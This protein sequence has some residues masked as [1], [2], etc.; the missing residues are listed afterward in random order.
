MAEDVVR[1]ACVHDARA[2]VHDSRPRPITDQAVIQSKAGPRNDQAVLLH[3]KG[4]YE[5]AVQAVKHAVRDSHSTE[6]LYSAHAAT[7]A[8]GA[9]VLLPSRHANRIQTYRMQLGA[10]TV[11]W[12]PGTSFQSA[13]VTTNDI[14]GL[15]NDMH[16]TTIF[17]IIRTCNLG[18]IDGGPEYLKPHEWACQEVLTR[19]AE[20]STITWRTE[21]MRSPAYATEDM[22]DVRQQMPCYIHWCAPKNDTSEE[23]NFSALQRLRVRRRH[24]IKVKDTWQYHT[25]RRQIANGSLRQ[26]LPTTPPIEEGLY[27]ISSRQ[28][29]YNVKQWCRSIGALTQATQRR[30]HIP[31]HSTRFSSEDDS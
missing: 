22:Q 18:F 12:R 17:T 1:T 29:K 28:W 13:I 7:W 20:Q 23:R 11:H 31:N 15:L 30:H 24:V 26:D 4:D 25:V 3:I 16:A 6:G 27:N 5:R 19:P 14:A 9:T 10:A 2:R 21:P 8:R